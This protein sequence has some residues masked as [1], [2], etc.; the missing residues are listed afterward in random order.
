V[1]I[2]REV[3][4]IIKLLGPMHKCKIL[5]FEMYGLVCV[6]IKI[7]NTDKIFAVNSMYVAVLKCTKYVYV[8]GY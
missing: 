4:Y 1:A 8:G 2:L 7:Q 6:Y 3:H 5:S